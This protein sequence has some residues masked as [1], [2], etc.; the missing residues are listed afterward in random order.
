M[1]V[2]VY[3]G[4]FDP[5]TN[6]HVD[7]IRRAS[8]QFDRLIVAVGKNS[9]KVS[10]FSPDD[11]VE[12]LIEALSGL[13]NVEIRIFEGL[14]V[15]FVQDVGANVIIRGLRA[16][17]DFENEFQMALANRELAPS[18]ETVFLMTSAEHMFVSSSIVREIAALSGPVESFVP[19][20]VAKRLRERQSR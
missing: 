10:M 1:R 2:A 18:I 20:S 6:G 16:I 15:E 9:P 8:A 14:L 11:R 3:P 7:L 5:P 4:S 19:A 12:M 13:A 17:S